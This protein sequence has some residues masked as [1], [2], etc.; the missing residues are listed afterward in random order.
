MGYVCLL[1]TGVN[2]GH[3]LIKPVLAVP[4]LHTVE[5][6][7]GTDDSDGHGTAMAGLALIGN[8]TEALS[9]SDP[10]TIDHRL[11]SVKILP[12]D[13]SNHGD[14]QHHGYLTIEAIAVS[15]GKERD[16]SWTN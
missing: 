3:P 4:D 12:E 8:L 7:W 9:S 2:N 16:L 6:A 13:G 11:E 14:A 15:N 1:D 5:P 10:V